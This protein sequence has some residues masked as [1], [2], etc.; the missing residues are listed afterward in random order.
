M[1]ADELDRRS[2]ASA[3]NLR[4][5]EESAEDWVQRVA[6]VDHAPGVGDV[7][8]CGDGRVTVAEDIPGGV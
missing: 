3:D 7:M 5:F 2:T 1:E 4:A 6:D 8:A